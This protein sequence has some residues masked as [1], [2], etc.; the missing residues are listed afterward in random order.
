MDRIRAEQLA[1]E[2]REEMS[3]GEGWSLSLPG[4]LFVR[5]GSDRIQ[6]LGEE[7]ARMRMIIMI[8]MLPLIIMLML[9]L[10]LM[11]VGGPGRIKW[12]P[13]ACVKR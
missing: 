3:W 13:Q 6:K 8:M 4:G 10:M 1:G 9:M 7:T 12:G 11:P 2:T 5:R